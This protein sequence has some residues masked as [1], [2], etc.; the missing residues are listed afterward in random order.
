MKH[1]SIVA[2]V[3]DVGQFRAA[4]VTDT[5]AG[6]GELALNLL[7]VPPDGVL[8]VYGAVPANVVAVL[9]QERP[10]QRHC[11]LRL[12]ECPDGGKGLLG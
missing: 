9:H 7:F 11:W 3:D 12:A 5:L 2:F 6:D 8:D 10:E 4:L 1:G